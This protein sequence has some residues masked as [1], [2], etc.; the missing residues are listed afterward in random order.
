MRNVSFAMIAVLTAVMTPA[1]FARAPRAATAASAPGSSTAALHRLLDDWD[2]SGFLPPSKPS[3][4]RIY[5]RD[6]YVTSGPDYAFMVSLIRAAIRE[7][8]LGNDA[9]ALTKIA[10]V[11]QLLGPHPNDSRS[12]TSAQAAIQRRE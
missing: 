10:T 8:G 9:A 4:F 1:A 3:Q 11:K 2:R 6:G 7:S 5:G 12:L